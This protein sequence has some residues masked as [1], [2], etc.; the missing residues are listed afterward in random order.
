MYETRVS[1]VKRDAAREGRGLVGAVPLVRS[2]ADRGEGGGGGEGGGRGG[3]RGR[4]RERERE[5][6]KEGRERETGRQ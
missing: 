3:G 6:E 1:P 5:R 4:E 2:A